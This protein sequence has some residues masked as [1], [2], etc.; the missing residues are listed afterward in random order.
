MRLFDQRMTPAAIAFGPLIELPHDSIR[1]HTSAYSQHTSAYSQH[2]SAYVSIPRQLRASRLALWSADWLAHTC[3]RQDERVRSDEITLLHHFSRA[4]YRSLSTSA[5][6][7]IRQHT[8]A[9]VSTPTP[10]QN[11]WRVSLSLSHLSLS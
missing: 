8:S 4:P 9:Y 5:Y 2:T 11:T 7:S 1:Q 6:V 3:A 10:L